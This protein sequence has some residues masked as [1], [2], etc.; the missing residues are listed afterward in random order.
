MHSRDPGKGDELFEDEFERTL[1]APDDG[2]ANFSGFVFPS[3]NYAKR[4]FSAKCIFNRA[5]FVGAADFSGATFCEPAIFSDAI[6]LQHANFWA[7]TFLKEAV[8]AWATFA[9]G[10]S[11]I[12]AKFIQEARFNWARFANATD[13][14]AARFSKDARFN[15]AVFV[16]DVHFNVIRPTLLPG[17]TESGRAPR[18]DPF[19]ATVF[20]RRADFREAT[21]SE[22]AEFRQ[23]QFRDDRAGEP[24]AIF[25]S[26]RFDKPMLVVFY[27]VHLGQALF[28]NCDV[29]EFRFT[30]VRWRSRAN[31]K[32]MV[33]EE[34]ESLRLDQVDT[35]ALR[36]DEGGPDRLNYALIAELYQQPKKNYD[37]R[38][39]YWTAGDFH[40]GEMEMKRLATPN[41]NPLSRWVARKVK[42]WLAREN[43]GF[44][45]RQAKRKGCSEGSLHALRCRWHQAM[46]LAAW[47][48]RA[49]EYG[50]SYGRPLFWLAVILVFFM[51]LFPVLGLRP[52]A[53]SPQE[54][55]ALGQLLNP[56]KAEL[57]VLSYSNLIRYRSL[58][59]GG[60]RV[61]LWSV[62]GHSLMTTVGVA[63]FQRDL[64]YD[65]CYP[66]GRLLAIVENVLT[67][68]L[69]AL[70]LLAIR[71]Q[72]RR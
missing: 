58:E 70:F 32:R 3:A 71:R 6:F 25:S 61:T 49:S 53:K 42:T 9:Q 2:I 23:T 17:T 59:V 66:W 15:A 60:A 36:A 13:F 30:K 28:H 37:D 19:I 11:F 31:G 16:G 22:R 63:A 5:T 46:G 39:D 72:F 7:S 47:Y 45:A 62:L 51:F 54:Q 68:T 33:F 57:A 14:S 64:A 27:G 67:S 34:D 26:A 50:E 20:E 29:S 18:W 56:A 52:T 55:A 8:F 21:F 10:A 40:Y 43:P 65:P 44:L 41:P 38:R 35:I 4:Q 69:V 24:S 48:K 12:T 1:A